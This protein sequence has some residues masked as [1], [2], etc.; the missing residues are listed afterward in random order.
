[1][2]AG[3]AQM[4]GLTVE[5]ELIGSVTTA[6]ADPSAKE[7]VTAAGR[8]VDCRNVGLRKAPVR[9]GAAAHFGRLST[10]AVLHT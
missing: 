8:A 3:A 7:A 6:R 10:V 2:L 5:V 4:H 9:G 1:M